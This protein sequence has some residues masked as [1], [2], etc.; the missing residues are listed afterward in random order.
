MQDLTAKL[1]NLNYIQ[2]NYIKR[3]EIRE[4]LRIE[5]H[6]RAIRIVQLEDIWVVQWLKWDEQVLFHVF[7]FDILG[8]RHELE[9]EMFS[10]HESISQS[11]K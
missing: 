6:V 7:H 5:Q 10:F 8:H 11:T 4:N 2:I 9:K 1:F 3:W